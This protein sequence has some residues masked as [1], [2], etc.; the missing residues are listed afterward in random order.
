[1]KKWIAPWLL[2]TVSVAAASAPAA[3]KAGT[4]A[5]LNTALSPEV[6]A[7]DLVHRMTLEEKASQLVNHARAIPRLNIPAYDWWSEALH[8]VAVKGTTEF[9]E[10]VGLAATFDPDGVHQMAQ[11]VGVEGRI[12]HDQVMAKNGHSST[13]EG[14]D[15]WAPNVN[16]FRDP[17]WGR[18]SIPDRS[19]G[20]CLRHRNAG[21]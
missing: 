9:P 5:Y 3:H 21:R 17:R 10:P 18:R 14:L 2:A 11:D 7:A 13:M 1:M 15:F 12:K 19:D 6:R 4:P 16:I 8:G 20:G